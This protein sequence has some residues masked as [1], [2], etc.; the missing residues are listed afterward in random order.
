MDYRQ[1]ILTSLP[2]ELVAEVCKYLNATQLVILQGVR[3][4][5]VSSIQ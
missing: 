3:A 5:Y 1:D 2:L 4:V